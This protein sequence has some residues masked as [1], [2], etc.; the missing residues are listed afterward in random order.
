MHDIL[1]VETDRGRERE[2]VC[3]RERR[4][5]TLMASTATVFIVSPRPLAFS[6]ST[7]RWLAPPSLARLG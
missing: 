6:G 2:C 4:Q 7:R 5:L 3:E 1:R